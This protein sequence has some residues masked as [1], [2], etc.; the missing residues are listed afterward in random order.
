MSKN[1][2]TF[3]SELII[4]DGKV[5]IGTS[6]PTS[7]F[8]VLGTA[9]VTGELKVTSIGSTSGEHIEVKHYRDN[10]GSVVYQSG[11][12]QLFSLSNDGEF[13]YVI[14]DDDGRSILDITKT[15]ITSIRETLSVGS[16]ITVGIGLTISEN[17]F[18]R[19]LQATDVKFL[20]TGSSEATRITA[21]HY[22]DNG[23][24]VVLESGE[25]HLFSVD[26]E[27]DIY[28]SI[29]DSEARAALTV[30]SSGITTIR[31]LFQNRVNFTSVGSTS[32]EQ[33]QINHYRNIAYQSD[34]DNRG[35]IS[36]DSPTGITTDGITYFPASL[37]A[38]TNGG[39]NVFSVSSYRYFSGSR[40]PVIDVTYDG[41]LGIGITNPSSDI[42]IIDKDIRVSNINFL[43]DSEINVDGIILT[44]NKN[45]DGQN[46]GQLLE[47]ENNDNTLFRINVLG[48]G[49]TTSDSPT[50]P[51]YT[52][53]D[54]DRTGEIRIF[55]TDVNKI[56]SSAPG[57]STILPSDGDMFRIDTY[58]PPFIGTFP[59]VTPAIRVDKFGYTEISRNVNQISGITT[60]GIATTTTSLEIN[61]TMTF[62]LINNT[63]LTIKVRGTD[64]VTRSGIVTLA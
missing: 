22:Q 34:I 29:N 51:I 54:V 50:T 33:I 37:F 24:S 30:S 1:R 47:L 46:T 57:F 20:S 45:N 11:D 43:S 15:G 27:P 48:I 23:G 62:E 3:P 6:T 38:L 40:Y 19:S 59:T 52:A 14:S 42:H 36:F 7:T 64:G 28:Y 39:G 35:A 4:R 56:L 5:G 55:D 60:V 17:S 44:K 61:A 26:N 2:I 53:V 32:D 25:N 13:A 31:D 16:T 63:T 49:L 41:K 21:K 10:G 9:E 12:K 18:L 8:N 58:N